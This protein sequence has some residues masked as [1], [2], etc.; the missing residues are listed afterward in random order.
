MS[1]GWKWSNKFIK[2]Y[3]QNALSEGGIC[4]NYPSGC[5]SCYIRDNNEVYCSKCFDDYVLNDDGECITC[6]NISE[7]GGN[8]CKRCGYNK[9]TN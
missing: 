7:I 2:C 9:D 4:R 5:E 8:G 1:T 3:E 6:S